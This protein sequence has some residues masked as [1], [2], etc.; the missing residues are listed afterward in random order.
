MLPCLPALTSWD[1]GVL[2]IASSSR[3]RFTVFLVLLAFKV[4]DDEMM[5]AS[6]LSLGRH[7]VVLGA[8]P[9]SVFGRFSCA[10]TV[11]C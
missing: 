1:C 7:P 2:L 11:K 3:G 8:F 9:L 5:S 4:L 6:P 10:R